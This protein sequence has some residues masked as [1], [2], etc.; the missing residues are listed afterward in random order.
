MNSNVTTKQENIWSRLKE[1]FTEAFSGEML[2]PRSPGDA[3][4]DDEWR[5]RRRRNAYRYILL[6]LAAVLAPIW[7]FNVYTES[8]LLVAGMSFLLLVL[9]ADIGFLS[10]G[11][12]SKASPLLIILISIALGVL[13]Y[14]QGQQFALF[15]QFPLLVLLPVLTKLRW[16]AIVGAATVL[17]LAPRVIEQFGV[18]SLIVMLSLAVSWLV[19]AWMMF[20]VREQAK[21]LTGM[22]ITDPLTGAHNRRYMELQASRALQSWVRYKTSVSLLLID[23]DHFKRINDKYGH[24]LGDR[25][26]Q[27]VV[28]RVRERVRESDVLCRFGGEEFVLLLSESND[29]K[30]ASVAEAL[31]K[32]IAS[33]NILPDGPMTI[34]VGICDVSLAKDVEH[35]FKLADNAMYVAKHNGRNRVEIARDDK[36]KVVPITKTVPDWR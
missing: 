15:F 32:S 33:S 7:A 2:S 21:R 28:N 30:A 29:R 18:T 23:I 6:V 25:A 1:H 35:W 17:L 14:Y 27:E 8:W 5:D 3:Q 31:C 10:T 22:A 26:L 20:A 16:A 13:A 34:S 36:P 12:E 9:M 4:H 11:H 24:A 19:S